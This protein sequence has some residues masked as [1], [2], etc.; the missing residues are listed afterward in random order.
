MSWDAISDPVENLPTEPCERAL[1]FRNGLTA[2]A[3]GSSMDSRAYKT[4]RAEFTADPATARVLP[5]ASRPTKLQLFLPRSIPRTDTSMT[6]APSSNPPI[7]A[8]Q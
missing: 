7:V 1:A 3:T 2:E 8:R 4:L 5:V 6:F